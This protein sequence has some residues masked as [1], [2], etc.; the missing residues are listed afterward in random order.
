MNGVTLIIINIPAMLLLLSA[1][2]IPQIFQNSFG[3]VDFQ[4]SK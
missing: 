3:L 4:I 1:F 2:K